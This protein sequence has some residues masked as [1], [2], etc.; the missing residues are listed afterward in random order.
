LRLLLAYLF[1]QPGKKLL[2]MGAEFGQRNEW[3]HDGSL[4]WS[5]IAQQNPHN[6]VQKL[7][8]TL[9]CLY[10][11]EPALHEQELQATGFQWIDAHDA[12][13]STLSWLRFGLRRE[14][15]MLIV[16]NFTPVPRHNFRVGVPRG[17][18]W[19]EILNSNAQEYGGSVEGNFGGV[20]AAPLAWHGQ[21]HL[22]T[23]TL[24]PLAVVAFKPGQGHLG[25][26]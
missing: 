19:Q 24:P 15:V 14:E 6:G 1:F 21:S 17:G 10:R 8:G 12:E 25:T 7:V 13:Q 11:T 5:I 18:F 3:R 22:I 23:V 16:C 20:E 4:D 9:N 2:F 26:L